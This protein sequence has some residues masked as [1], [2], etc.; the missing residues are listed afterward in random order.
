MEN[1]IIDI[2]YDKIKDYN[3]YNYSNEEVMKDVK[4]EKYENILGENCIKIK[5]NNIEYVVSCNEIFKGS[6]EEWYITMIE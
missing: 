6:E 5:I 2:I 1:E 3:F 4:I